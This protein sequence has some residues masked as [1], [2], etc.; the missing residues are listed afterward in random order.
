MAPIYSP[1]KEF[2]PCFICIT[3]IYIY[4]IYI[5]IYICICATGNSTDIGAML[6]LGIGFCRGKGFIADS[7]RVLIWDPCPL[8]LPER[9]TEAHMVGQSFVSLASHSGGLGG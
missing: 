3:Y 9:S 6:R 5:Y 8:G 7:T 4:I 2:R 1:L